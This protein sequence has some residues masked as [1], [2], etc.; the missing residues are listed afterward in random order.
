MSLVKSMRK[1]S[2]KI[3]VFL[4][5]FIMVGFV[6]GA[7]LPVIIRQFTSWFSS[8]QSAATYGDNIKVGY[9]DLNNAQTELKIL[10]DLMADQFLTMPINQQGDRNVKNLLLSQVLFPDPKMAIGIS[11]LLKDPKSN[12]QASAEEIDSFLTQTEDRSDVSWLLLKTEASNAGIAVPDASTRQ[13]LSNMIP[14]FTNNA[15]DAGTIVSNISKRYHKQTDEIIRVFSDLR[16]VIAYST[17]ILSSEDITIAQMQSLLGL[18]GEKIKA[19][20]VRFEI[21]S[22]DPNLPEPN[23]EEITAQFDK[24]KDSVSGIFSKENPYGLDINSLRQ[25]S[26]TT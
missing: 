8:G 9:I 7:S 1:Y 2:N 12:L 24:Y 23:A 13:L 4:L 18:R 11:S 10:A 26:W 15:V 20:M 22:V 16:S 14:A 3:M 17:S 5:I 19:E 6:L 25:L 21:S